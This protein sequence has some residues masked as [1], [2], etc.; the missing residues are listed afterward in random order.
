[1]PH[2]H[3][4]SA[5]PAHHGMALRQVRRPGGRRAGPASEA[6][7]DEPRKRRKVGSSY[8]G[9]FR[10]PRRGSLTIRSH[11]HRATGSSSEICQRSLALSLYSAL[12]PLQCLLTC[13]T[14][15]GSPQRAKSSFFSSTSFSSPFSLLQMQA[16][17]N[18]PFSAYRP[19]ASEEV[20]SESSHK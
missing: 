3:C 15:T 9:W 13:E 8:L 1:M 19:C 7:S 10:H 4:R 5:G 6:H 18:R 20:T 12:L 16:G 14:F 17:I 11:L 2:R